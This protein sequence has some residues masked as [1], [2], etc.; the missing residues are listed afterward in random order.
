MKVRTTHLLEAVAFLLVPYL[1]AALRAGSIA[2]VEMKYGPLWPR[3]VAFAI[4]LLASM[5]AL[6]L[7]STRLRVSYF[8]VLL[9]LAASV[10]VATALAVVFF[11]LFERLYVGRLLLAT[12]AL[13]AFAA[14]ALIRLLLWRET[15]GPAAGD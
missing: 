8:G 12:T 1:A 4:A 5:W 10:C 11:Y 2:A 13:L 15:S 14:A 9:R 7:Y 6:E 3:A